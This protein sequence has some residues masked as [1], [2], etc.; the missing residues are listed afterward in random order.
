MHYDPVKNSDTDDM[1]Y[2][3]AFILSI[4]VLFRSTFDV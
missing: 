3:D 1:I 4:V 2:Y